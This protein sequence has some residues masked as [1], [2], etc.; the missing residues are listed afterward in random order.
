[1]TPKKPSRALSG[2]SAGVAAVIQPANPQVIS[3]NASQVGSA[4]NGSEFTS[5]AQP[6]TETIVRPLTPAEQERALRDMEQQIPE[7]QTI[8]F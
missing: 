3:E 5:P 8:V 6:P 4:Y 2:P 7:G 1:L